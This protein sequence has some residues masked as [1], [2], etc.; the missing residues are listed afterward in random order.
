MTPAEVLRT[1]EQ[2]HDVRGWLAPVDAQVLALMLG[3]QTSGGVSGDVLEV[4]VYEGRSAIFLAK[5]LEPEERLVVCDLFG[6]P[7]PNA[8]NRAENDAQYGSLQRATFEENCRRH[9]GDVPEVH[10]CPSGD[11]AD[12]LAAGRFRLVHLDGSHSYE[13]VR[14]DIDLAREL[15]GHG[16]VVVFDDYRSAHTPGVAAAAWSAVVSGGL[17]AL[18]VTPSKLYAAVRRGDPSIAD[19][20]AGLGALDVAVE[21]DEVAGQPLLRVVPPA[22]AAGGT[23]S[24]VRS[25]TPP[26][27]W[28]WAGVGAAAYRRRRA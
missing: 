16:G 14:S 9:L 21:D 7:A 25:L 5:L 3:L 23:K 2:L 24:L 8:V 13:V 26:A 19:V 10:Q 1:H 20:R 12:R 15:L 27:V 11:L 22:P 17:T 6:S 28:R 18:C 4:G